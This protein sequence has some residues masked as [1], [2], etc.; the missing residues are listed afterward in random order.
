MAAKRIL[1]VDNEQYI[2]EVAKICLETVAGWDVLTA[3]S[4]KEGIIQAEA[5]QPDAILL[6][7]MMPDMDGIT[8]F[9]KLQ[10]NAATQEIP[11][12]LLTAK[13]QAS[14]RRRYAQMGIKTA[15]AKPFNPL[16]LAGQVAEALG[17]SL[18]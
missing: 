3:S 4:G 18:D 11:V 5:Y 10:A 15:I 13:I 9:E 14:D 8:T 17:W 7:V 16:E 6:D 2:Q 12:I 1:V